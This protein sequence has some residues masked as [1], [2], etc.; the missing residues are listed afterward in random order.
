MGEQW[1]WEE[2]RPARTKPEMSDPWEEWLDFFFPFS[3]LTL[4][5]TGILQSV[6]VAK[7]AGQSQ[8]FSLPRRTLPPT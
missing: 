3:F 7:R 6:C 2:G 4:Y 8:P 1:P 5:G